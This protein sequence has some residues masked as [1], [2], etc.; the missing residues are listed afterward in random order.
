[1]ANQ[2]WS[3]VDHSGGALSAAGL[4]TLSAAKAVA[5]ALGGEAV[6]VVLGQGTQAVADEAA[7]HGV[8]KVLHADDA[9]FE[10]YTTHAYLGVIS[11]LAKEHSPDTVILSHGIVGRDLAARLAVRL[12]GAVVTDCT[13]LCADGGKLVAER[14]VFAGKL[15]AT[16]EVDGGCTRVVTVRPKAFEKSVAGDGAAP[17][18]AVDAGFEE[19]AA[20]PVVEV[21][22]KDGARVGLTEADVVVSAGRGIKEPENFDIIEKLADTLGAAVGASRAVVDAGW[23]E[24]GAQVGQTG[25]V[26]APKLYFAVGISGAIQHLVG[27]QNSKY[28]FAINKDADAPIFQKADFGIVGDLF[29]VVPE[30]TK[31]FSEAGVGQ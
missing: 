15:I 31:A 6:A 27:M 12:D 2:V 24:H 7:K 8:A 10:H 5:S 28:I 17:V 9:A 25:L 21:K 29:E 4:E 20:S 22:A 26:V 18:E 19:A 23:R 14:P 16:V 30:L 13:S 3:I 11:K 1:M